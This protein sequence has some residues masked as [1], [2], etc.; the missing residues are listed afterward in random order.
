MGAEVLTVTTSARRLWALVHRPI[1]H[2]LAEL[3]SGPHEF[4]LGGGP[5]MAAPWH[6]RDTFDI[7]LR[8][9]PHCP[10]EGARQPL[11]MLFQDLCASAQSAFGS[12]AQ[13]RAIRS[14]QT[15]VKVYL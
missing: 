4:R 2:A 11:Q 14:L 10:A 15:P 8:R 12:A 6:Q 3:G 5:V 7:D 9:R 13:G 1:R